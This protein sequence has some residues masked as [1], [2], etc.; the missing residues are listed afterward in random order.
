MRVLLAYDGSSGAEQ[1]LALAAT[2]RWPAGSTL[3]VAAVVEPAV[4]RTGL[5][6]GAIVP[7]P[8]IDAEV[9]KLHQEHVSEAARR[10]RG[11]GQQSEGVVLHGRPA[12]ALVDEATRS[13]ADLVIAGS[14]GHG[15]VAS[16]LLGSV[17]TEL[18]ESAPCPVLVARTDG[19][20]R[21]VLAVDGSTSAEAAA[22]LVATSPMFEG[23]PIH[24]VSVADVM[25]P[26]QFGLAPA[27]YH[28]AAAEHAAY[29]AEAQ[30][31]H[32]R[33]A[34]ETA[35]RLQ[36]AGRQAE[37]TMR[38]GGAADEIIDL[39]TEAGADLIVMGSQGRT[40]LARIVLGSV[41]RN[42]LS[43]SRASVLV[44]RGQPG[45]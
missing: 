38:T 43:G 25:Q 32:T 29:F 1:A 44:V 23:V 42:V 3:T 8:E 39:A 7:A 34:A 45:S 2:S 13:A 5:A 31:N 19:V 17:S 12:T 6:P 4:M 41:A 9:T 24:V 36:A 27:A 33:M 35:A 21:V 22:S 20:S 30:D 10:L 11:T 14:R 15:R 40:G 37:S 16:L 18:V 28:R 26:V